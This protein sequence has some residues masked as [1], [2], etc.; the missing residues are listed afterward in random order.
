MKPKD[1]NEHASTPARSIGQRALPAGLWLGAGFAMTQA[2]RLGSSLILTRLLAPDLYGLMTLGNVLVASLT[3]LSDVGLVQNIVQGRRA[4]DP[5]F[6][7]TVWTLGIVRGLVIGGLMLCVAV[8]FWALGQAWP[9]ALSGTYADPRLPIVFAVLALVPMIGGFESTNIALAQRQIQ[10]GRLVR[11][12][13]LAQLVSTGVVI[14]CAW[15]WPAVWV[16]PAGWVCLAAVKSMLSH[17]LPGPGN[18][19]AWDRQAIR[20]VWAFSK[21]ILLSSALGLAYREGDRLLLAGLIG[22]HELGAYGIGILLISA[23]QQI[24][25]RMAGM[26]G[27]PALAEVMRERPERLRQAYHRCRLP[28][29]LF[30]LGLGGLLFTGADAI[31]GVLY[32]ARYASAGHTLSLLA[33][34]LVAL[35]YTVFDQYLVATGETRQLYKR[36]LSRVLVLYAGIPIGFWLGGL[37]GALLAILLANFSALP[38]IFRMK[39]RRGLLDLAY[40]CKVLLVFPLAAGLGALL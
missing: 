17:W 29:D 14:A 24:V 38:V 40:E 30:C 1:N 18:R 33:L 19:P 10:M 3:L 36:M 20:E 26:V 28:L 31:I 21:W 13:V 12:E 8:A 35:R 39:H 34:G 5:R 25:S 11:N 6:L 2:I 9:H 7:N 22:P 23:A 27:M 32:D 37:T 4:D 16:L 15:R